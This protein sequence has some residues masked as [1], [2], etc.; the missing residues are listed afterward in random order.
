[1]ANRVSYEA[2]PELGSVRM[3][4]GMTSVF[5]AV[6]SLAASDLAQTDRHRELAVSLASHDQ[7]VFGIGCVNFDVS[8]L[9]WSRETFTADRAF[10][11]D[12]INAAQGKAGWERLGYEPNEW[13]ARSRL[14]ELAALIRALRVEDALA[15]PRHVWRYTDP[16]VQFALCPTH[17]V[18]L[19]SGG[20]VLCN[21]R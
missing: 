18:Y 6:L 5:I 3:S 10:L 12:V 13:S 1:M 17:K 7:G 9:P 20:C 16:P 8:E 11:L 21:D 14:A 2:R 19:H 15:G 4:N